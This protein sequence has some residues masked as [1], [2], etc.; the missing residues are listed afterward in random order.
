M[1]I[2]LSTAAQMDLFH[3]A[4]DGLDIFGPAQT[5]RYEAGLNKTLEFLAR[6]PRATA[7]HGEYTPPVRV[8][9]YQAHIIIYRIEDDD[10]FVVRICHS[11]EDWTRFA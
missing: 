3:I 4:V 5:E 9:P 1:A 2:K 6:N 10:V 11:R 8:C 7:E